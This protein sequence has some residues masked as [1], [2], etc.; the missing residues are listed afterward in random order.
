MPQSRDIYG[1]VGCKPG[2]QFFTKRFL[3]RGKREIHLYSP[4]SLC[5]T[6]CGQALLQERIEELRVGFSLAGV[7][8]LTDKE[9]H[10]FVAPGTIRCDLLRVCCQ[11]L[12]DQA[13][14][15]CVIADL[16][17]A[18]FSTNCLWRFSAGAHLCKNILGDLAANCSF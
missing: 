17:K 15:C 4:C 8:D 12:V 18:L 6:V 9:S 3:L 13:E 2:P 11:H 7:H 1:D 10:K 16:R 14:E 5:V